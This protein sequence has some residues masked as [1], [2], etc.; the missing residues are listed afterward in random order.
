MMV[1]AKV[2]RA[3]GLRIVVY[4]DDILIMAPTEKEAIR[5]RDIFLQLLTD[6]GLAMNA[7]NQ[8]SSRPS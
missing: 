4:Q 3:K 7:R 8:Y 6:F 2:A 1:L 5:A